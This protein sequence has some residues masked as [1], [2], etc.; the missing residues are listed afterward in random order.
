MTAMRTRLLAPCQANMGLVAATVSAAAPFFKS[1]GRLVP[2]SLDPRT[3]PVAC[4]HLNCVIGHAGNELLASLHLMPRVDKTVREH[5][6]AFI[7]VVILPIDRDW[8][9]VMRGCTIRAWEGAC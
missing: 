6:R 4:A 5:R 8:D 2:F 7:S 1:S 3:A 9:H